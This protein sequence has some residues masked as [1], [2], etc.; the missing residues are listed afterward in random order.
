[1]LTLKFHVRRNHVWSDTLGAV[2]KASFNPV[3]PLCITF[4][5]EPAVNEGGP[6]RESKIAS[7]RSIFS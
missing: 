3:N 4:I 7:D 2:K 1:M 6:R 5:G